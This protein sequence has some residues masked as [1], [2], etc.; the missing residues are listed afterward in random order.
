MRSDADVARAMAK[1]IAFMQRYEARAGI[2]T[3]VATMPPLMTS[4][5]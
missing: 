4:C 1:A 2:G 5:L 3:A